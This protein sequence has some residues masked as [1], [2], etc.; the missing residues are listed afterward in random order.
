MP[1]TFELYL[2]DDAGGRR[3]EPLLCTQM[4]LMHRAREVLLSSGSRAV[5]VWEAGEHLFTLDR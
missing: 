2:C 1:R 3:F 4:E 5:E